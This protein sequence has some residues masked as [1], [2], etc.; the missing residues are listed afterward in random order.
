MKRLFGVMIS[1]IMFSTFLAIPVAAMETDQSIISRTVEDLGNGL[2]FIETISVPSVQP[3]SN[4]KTGTK[5]SECVYN[6]T[7]IFTISVTG[8]FTYDG[9][10]SQATSA[11]GKMVAYAEGVTFNDRRAY[12]SGASAIAT[13]SAT[14][15]GTTIPK[16]VTLTCDKNGNL[17]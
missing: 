5:T 2:Y 3:Y 8:I 4:S 6:G 16:T 15:N 9:S 7:T 11:T 14:Y 1:I 17:S 12:V 10:T 13:G